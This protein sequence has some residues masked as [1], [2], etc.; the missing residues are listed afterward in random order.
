MTNEILYIDQGREVTA[1]LTTS[2]ALLDLTSGLLEQRT[3]EISIRFTTNGNMNF[4]ATPTLAN[5]G[6]QITKNFTTNGFYGNGNINLTDMIFMEDFL[7]DMKVIDFLSGL[8]KT[9]N[10]T[11]YT[12]N[13]DDTIYVQTFDDFMTLG[14]ER[15]ITSMVK[16]DKTDVTR[17]IPYSAVNFQYASPKTQ[18]ASRYIA[19]YSETFGNLRYQAP[20]KY[21]GQSFDLKTPFQQSPLTLIRGTNLSLGWWVNNDGKTVAGAPYLFFNRMAD[22]STTPIVSG[23]F[24]TACCPSHVSPNQNHSLC[25]NQQWDEFNE[26]INEFS[27]FERFYKQYIVQ[28]FELKGRIVRLKAVVT[29]EFILNYKINDTIIVAGRKY[30][31]NSVKINLLTKEADFELLVKVN[32]YTA[33]VLT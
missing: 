30:Y 3:Y 23:V 33:S 32:D 4:S 8:F 31:I 28:T 19:S 29:V 2:F 24:T 10:L 17:P 18:M 1:G 14:T 27:L 21:E 22:V 6:L 13:N 20:E 9:F 16:I 11:A 5:F 25:F 15:D 7:P 26:D 12:E